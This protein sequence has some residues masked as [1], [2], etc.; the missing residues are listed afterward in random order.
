MTLGVPDLSDDD[1]RRRAAEMNKRWQAGEKKS[2]LEIEYRGDA[3]SHGKHFT[4]YTKRWLGV[5]TETKSSPTQ[6]IERLEGLLRSNGISPVMWA[7]CTSFFACWPTHLAS[8][9]APGR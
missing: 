8:V 6:Y 9:E 2:S 3:K 4:S 5:T 1:Q 7:T